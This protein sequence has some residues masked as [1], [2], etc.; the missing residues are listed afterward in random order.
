MISKRVIVDNYIKLQ[1][2]SLS[3]AS[4]RVYGA[5]MYIRSTDPTNNRKIYLL[6]SKSRI[7]PLKT[8]TLPRL[9]LCVAMLLN[10]LFNNVIEALNVIF[11]IITFWSNSTIVL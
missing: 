2:H 7:A 11:Q 6:G 1:L 9:E 5:S 8:Q 10:K 4:R 3:D